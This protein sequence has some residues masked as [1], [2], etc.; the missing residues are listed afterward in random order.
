MTIALFARAARAAALA[1]LA[2]L[3]AVAAPAPAAAADKIRL[4]ALRFV[5]SAPLFIAADKGYYAAEGLDAELR[6]FE[7]A[8]PVAL[9]VA[10]G[11]CDVGMTGF[12]G[13]FFNLAGKGAL[14]VIAAQSREE[15]GFDFVG[16]VASNKA[17]EAGLKSVKDLPGRNFGITQLGSTFHY[18]IGMLAA[19]YGWPKDAVKLTP[20]QTVPNMVAAVTS[21]QVDAVALPSFI[22]DG[23]AKRGEAKLIGWVHEHTPWQLGAIFVPSKLVDSD[24]KR[25]ER[26][27]AAYLKAAAEYHKAFNARDAAGKRAFGA[28]AAALLPIIEKYTKAAPAQIYAGAPFIDPEGRLLVADI[29]RQ[30]AW[31]KAQGLVDKDVEAKTFL[32]L[33]FIKGHLDLPK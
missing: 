21:G 19:K 17:H 24:R 28:E 27:L 11:D 6:F 9:G 15:P 4:C 2:G 32:D 5:S 7:A 1:A 26:F 10:A 29:Y 8:Q 12:T 33:S 20:L 3:V 25:I 18:N 31:Y 22:A 16:F 30:V 14:K 23:L 13:G